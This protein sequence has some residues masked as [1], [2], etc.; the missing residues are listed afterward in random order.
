MSLDCPKKW[1]ILV[2]GFTEVG[3]GPEISLEWCKGAVSGHTHQDKPWGLLAGSEPPTSQNRPAKDTLEK[4]T[5]P[6][7]PLQNHGEGSTGSGQ[8]GWSIWGPQT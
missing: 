8:K 2:N 6:E 5:A 4:A 7:F 1:R 3:T